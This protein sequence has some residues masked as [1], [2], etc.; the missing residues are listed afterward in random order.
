V[1][2]ADQTL[3]TIFSLTLHDFVMFFMS[4]DRK[5]NEDSKN[6]LKILIFSLQVGF[7]GNFVPDCQNVFLADQILTTIFYLTLHDFVVFFIALDR[8]FNED[9]KNVL[10]TKIFLLQLGFTGN[11]V[12]DCQNVFLADQ[13]LTIIFCLTLHDFVVFFTSLDRKFNEDSKN[14]LKTIIFSLQVSF[15]GNF[16]PD[17]RNV[18]LADH[19]LTT[20]FSLTLHDFAVSFMSLDRKFNED[21]KKVLKTIIFLL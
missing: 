8:K 13:T 10:K 5:F 15:T 9:S 11:F 6:V 7:R 16:V 3:T 4:L 14:V 17:C 18:F 1:F 21:S 2:L 19:N 12:P 20:I